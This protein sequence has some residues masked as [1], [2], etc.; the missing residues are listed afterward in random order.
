[1]PLLPPRL[2]RHWLPE[3]PAHREDNA[4][5]QRRPATTCVHPA[6]SR[7][8]SAESRRLQALPRSSAGERVPEQRGVQHGLAERPGD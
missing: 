2:R 1:M 4:A 7:R 8:T 3:E 6:T 5:V